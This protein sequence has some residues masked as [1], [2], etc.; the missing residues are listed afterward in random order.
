LRLVKEESLCA[1]DTHFFQE[2]GNFLRLDKFRDRFLPRNGRH[3]LDALH[4]S[5]I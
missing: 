2:T 1:A 3:F 5:S 4:D